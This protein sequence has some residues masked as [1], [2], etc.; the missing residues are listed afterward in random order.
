M[1]RERRERT[2]P[3]PA[4]RRVQRARTSARRSRPEG[5]D[6]PVRAGGWADD[7]ALFHLRTS[8]VFF[9]CPLC[10]AA[11][12]WRYIVA[13]SRPLKVETSDEKRALRDEKDTCNSYK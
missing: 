7:K 2:P 5:L 1:E 10:G 4:E 13:K 6:A 9:H 8:K 3:V 12:T 11:E